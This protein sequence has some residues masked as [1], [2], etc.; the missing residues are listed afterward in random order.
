M[1]K[2]T[3]ETSLTPHLIIN[4]CLGNLVVRGD[5]QER[6]TVSVHGSD[7]EVGW[8]LEG[9]TLTLSVPGNGSLLC[10]SG[11]TLT[12]KKVLGNLRVER[13]VGP[14]AVAA[15]HGN[16]TLRAVGPVSLDGVLG[17]LS[18]REVAGQLE[19]QDVRG[20]VRVRGVGAELLLGGV[21]GNLVADGLQDGLR[22]DTVRGNARLGPDFFPNTTLR[23][24][25]Y[26][27]LTVLVPASASLRV[28]LRAGGQALSLIHI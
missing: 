21:A 13:L 23:L 28:A 17:N 14:A 4:E 19:A 12:I 18:A 16:T 11:T 22:V 3:I 26:A 20:N 6:I 5:A 15:V 8:E 10:P 24:R 25:G 2:R 7:N 27:N 1:I 9:D